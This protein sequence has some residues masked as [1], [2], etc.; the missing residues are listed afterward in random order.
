MWNIFY[1]FFFFVI[2]IF[3]EQ[4]KILIYVY[5]FMMHI[6]YKVIYKL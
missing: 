5:G 4:Y 2:I 6:L 1:F 3:K